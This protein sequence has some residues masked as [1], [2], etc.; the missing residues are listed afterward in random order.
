MGLCETDTIKEIAIAEFNERIQRGEKCSFDEIHNK[1]RQEKGYPPLETSEQDID[2]IIDPIN[3]KQHYFWVKLHHDFFDT[4]I[5]KKLRRKE[6]GDTLAL[7]Y[8]RVI[9][10]SLKHNGYICY[11]GMGDD[12]TEEISIATGENI[13]DCRVLVNFLLDNGQA[14]L[15]DDKSYIYIHGYEDCT[16][17]D[18]PK[19]R[20]KH[21]RIRKKQQEQNNLLS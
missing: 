4:L 17:A 18:K 6:K 15:S 9:L 2:E 21:S 11:E 7:L 1:L 3:D 10:L 16:G 20:M 19:T 14:T 8:Q 12:I 5:I 13:D